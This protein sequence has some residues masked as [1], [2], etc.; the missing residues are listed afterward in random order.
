MVNEKNFKKKNL[1]V[2]LLVSDK[3]RNHSNYVE[4]EKKKGGEGR[5]TNSRE[6]RKRRMMKHLI[7]IKK[8]L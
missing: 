1:N 6:L 7:F 5:M 2:Y 8:I 4:G 3:P